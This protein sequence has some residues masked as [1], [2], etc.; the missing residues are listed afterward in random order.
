[1]TAL[2]V[3]QV[4]QGGSHRRPLEC[5]AIRVGVRCCRRPPLA[6]WERR[7]P[8]RSFTVPIVRR[9]FNAVLFVVFAMLAT[10]IVLDVVEDGRLDGIIVRALTGAAAQCR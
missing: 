8:C 2:T 5:V 6:A 4:A 7:R 3:A 9:T 1:M 10:Y